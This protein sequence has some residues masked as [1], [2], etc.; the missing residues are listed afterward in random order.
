MFLNDVKEE[1]RRALA[2]NVEHN[3]EWEVVPR[4]QIPVY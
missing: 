2:K 3:L 1:Q 4:E